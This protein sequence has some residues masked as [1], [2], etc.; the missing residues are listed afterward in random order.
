MASW[1]VHAYIKFI[2]SLKHAKQVGWSLR[3]KVL[4]WWVYNVVNCIYWLTIVGIN[5]MV[6]YYI[7]Q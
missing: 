1:F 6:N 3:S 4:C 7:L 5:V 2:R